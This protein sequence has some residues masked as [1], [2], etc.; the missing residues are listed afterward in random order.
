MI[1]PAL[2][3][4][5]ERVDTEQG[6]MFVNR[7]KAAKLGVTDYRKDLA[8]LIG[9]VEDAGR[10]TATGTALKTTD[11]QGNELSASIVSPQNVPA[12]AA[13]DRQMFPQ[14]AKQEVKPAQQ[15]VAERQQDVQREQLAAV[16]PMIDTLVKIG[17]ASR[18]GQQ[19]QEPQQKPDENADAYNQYLAYATSEKLTPMTREEFAASLEK[20][21][22]FG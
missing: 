4:G 10:G 19:Y 16:D 12:Q 21:K 11:A 3:A 17:E 5:F 22:D 14:A 13:L 15:V 9:K 18:A 7:E 6:P 2:L 8:K 1:D 20:N